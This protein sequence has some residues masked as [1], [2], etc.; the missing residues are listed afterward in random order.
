MKLEPLVRPVFFA[1]VAALAGSV[2]SCSIPTE[3]RD[4]GTLPT[5]ASFTTAHVSQF[6]EARCAGLDCHGQVGRPLRLYSQNGLRLNSNAD[7]TRVS[8]PTTRDEQIKNYQS[9]VGL[10][11]EQLSR[12]FESKGVDDS[13]WF[14]LQLLKK[15]LGLDNDGIRHKGG[16]VL[17]DV[18]QDPGWVC[19][20]TW[21]AGLKPNQAACDDASKL[22]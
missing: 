13:T 22:K 3:E 4:A 20:Y 14:T 10:E 16:Q 19:L 11:P 12:T 7:G 9:V 17:R 6:M 8:G 5:Q 15:P 18:Q 2:M 21:A 1:A